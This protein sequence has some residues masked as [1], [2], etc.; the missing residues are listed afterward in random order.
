M[1]SL[2]PL[3]CLALQ[4]NPAIAQSAPTPS[5]KVSMETCVQAA[6]A[7]LEGDVVKLEL[8]TE[9]GVLTYEFEIEGK[10]RTME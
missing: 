3:A 9:R 7:K 1:K 5:T 4:F 10:E 8:K 6:R 2:I